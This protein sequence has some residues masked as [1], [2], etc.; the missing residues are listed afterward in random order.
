V[1]RLIAGL[2]LLVACSDF[3]APEPFLLGAASALEFTASAAK[4]QLNVS[5][6][7][8]LHFTLRNPTTDTVRVSMLS[9]VHLI[10]VVQREAQ[11]LFAREHSCALETQGGQLLELSPDSSISTTLRILAIDGK[12]PFITIDGL[13]LPR[14]SYFAF[15]ELGYSEGRSSLLE[16]SVR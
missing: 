5:D 2:V 11:V 3:T 10:P 1:R 6:T 8:T 14:G 4:T 7:V 12:T 15:A 9:C 16:F 13:S